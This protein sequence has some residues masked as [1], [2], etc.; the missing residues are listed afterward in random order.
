[1][2]NASWIQ[3]L[4]AKID[5]AGDVPGYRYERWHRATPPRAL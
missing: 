2:D 1:L 3:H 4:E 5:P